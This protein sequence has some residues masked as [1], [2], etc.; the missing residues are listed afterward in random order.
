MNSGSLCLSNEFVWHQGPWNT[1]L[2][3]DSENWFS[4]YDCGVKKCKNLDEAAAHMA[5][6]AFRYKDEMDDT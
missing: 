4:D 1:R 5:V 3:V 6:M 2:C